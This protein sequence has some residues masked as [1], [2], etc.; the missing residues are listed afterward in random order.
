M[1]AIKQYLKKY[2]KGKH[3]KTLNTNKKQKKNI[4]NNKQTNIKKT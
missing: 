1:E 4:E 3:R 2:K